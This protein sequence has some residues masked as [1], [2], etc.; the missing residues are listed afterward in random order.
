MGYTGATGPTGVTGVAN[1][2]AVF[3]SV[4][5]TANAV[6]LAQNQTLTMSTV[7][8][9]YQYLVIQGWQKTTPSGPYLVIGVYPVYSGGNWQ[10]F[11]N[12]LMTSTFTGTAT[13]NVI[14]YTVTG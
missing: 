2:N 3:N 13:I 1:I 5:I 8:G 6:G 10:I 11:V 4:N 9:P 14:Y 12:L 7:I